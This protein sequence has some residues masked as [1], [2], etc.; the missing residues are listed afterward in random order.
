MTIYVTF[1]FPGEVTVLKPL[2]RET[3]SSYALLVSASDGE[4]SSE[5]TLHIDVTDVNDEKP[6]FTHEW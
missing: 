1:I 2:D 3:N 4:Q 5:I 6:T